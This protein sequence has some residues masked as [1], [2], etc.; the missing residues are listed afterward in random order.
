MPSTNR[1]P[2]ITLGRGWGNT[3][4]RAGSCINAEQGP[5]P[6][7]AE[8]DGRELMEGRIRVDGGGDVIFCMMQFS[9]L[10]ILFF[11]SNPPMCRACS[12][13]G[14]FFL[15]ISYFTDLVASIKGRLYYF[16]RKGL[17]LSHKVGRSAKTSK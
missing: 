1:K 16:K 7:D 9:T 8:W 15:S 6:T 5:L 14:V 2:G 3:V 12:I 13:I 10:L 17:W 4:D 11:F